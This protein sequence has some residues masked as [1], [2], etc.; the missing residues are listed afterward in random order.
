MRIDLEE[1]EPKG[2]FEMAMRGSLRSFLGLQNELL[3]FREAHKI[4][5]SNLA[6]ELGVSQPMVSK[7]ENSNTEIQ[8]ATL[9]A[10]AASLG[11]S[12]KFEIE[13]PVTN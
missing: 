4:S 7:I 10:Y 1:L 2:P 5:Q 12:I 11:L 3:D 8:V 6:V 9:I 13:K